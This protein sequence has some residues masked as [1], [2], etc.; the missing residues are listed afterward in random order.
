MSILLLNGMP[1]KLPAL[2][3]VTTQYVIEVATQSEAQAVARVLLA[4]GFACAAPLK[5]AKTERWH[6]YAYRAVTEEVTVE[7]T[8]KG[9]VQ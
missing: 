4:M 6:L 9:G 2:Q 7:L 8:A 1:S 3:T 5:V